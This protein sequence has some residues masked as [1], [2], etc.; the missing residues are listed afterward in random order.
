MNLT[1]ASEHDH[2][3]ITEM[4]ED[5]SSEIT[6]T[7]AESNDQSVWTSTGVESATRADYTTSY[8]S[9][10]EANFGPRV[11]ICRKTMH[12]LNF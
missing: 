7:H 5:E 10:E 4:G 9:D 1:A 3:Q 8:Y 6:P 2:P 12:L 11:S